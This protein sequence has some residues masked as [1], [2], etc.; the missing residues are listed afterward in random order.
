MHKDGHDI[1]LFFETSFP[2]YEK[3][4]LRLVPV[5]ERGHDLA[6]FFDAVQLLHSDIFQPSHHEQ[7]ISS[8]HRK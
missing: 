7:M 2:G 6:G 5:H 1:D 3:M 8:L 4:T